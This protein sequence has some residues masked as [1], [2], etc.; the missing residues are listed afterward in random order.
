MLNRHMEGISMAKK[1]DYR[2]M[3]QEWQTED[4]KFIPGKLLNRELFSRGC[5]SCHGYKTSSEPSKELPYCSKHTTVWGL[6]AKLKNE[7]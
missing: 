7:D 5:Y 2:V 1:C 6:E 4:N 3:A